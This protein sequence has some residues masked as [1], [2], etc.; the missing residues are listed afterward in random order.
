MN[1]PKETNPWRPSRGKEVWRVRGFWANRSGRGLPFLRPFRGLSR[2]RFCVEVLFLA[3]LIVTLS[4]A[5]G[6]AAGGPLPRELTLT[7]PPPR[8]SFDPRIPVQ[9]PV[10]SGPPSVAGT[11]PEA[12]SGTGPVSVA[13]GISGEFGAS[14][15]GGV[16]SVPSSSSLTETPPLAVSAA[17]TYLAQF[18]LKMQGPADGTIFLVSGSP[19]ALGQAFQT[20]LAPWA[21]GGTR[22]WAYTQPPSVPRGVPIV[23]LSPPEALGTGPIHP[24]GL[25]VSLAHPI[26]SSGCGGALIPSEVQNAYNVTPVLTSGDQGQGETLGIVDTY[27]PTEPP[28]LLL[29][30]LGAFDKCY[31]L[32]NPAVTFAFPVP[33]GNMNSSGSTGWAAEDALDLEWAHAMAPRA[34]IVMVFSPNA[35]YGLYYG[36]DW[37]VANRMA[38]VISLSWGE[39]EI[40]TYNGPCDFQCNAT[41]DGSLALLGPV[42]DRAAAEGISVF[43][44]SGDCGANGGTSLFTPWYPASDPHAIGVGGTVLTLSSTGGYGSETAWS[45]TET[46]CTNSG[47]SGGGFSILGRPPWQSGP[48][49]GRFLQTTRGVP[50]V[51]LTAG[52]PLSLIL[53][54]SAVAVEGTSD[55]APQ[56][57]GLGALLAERQGGGV[58]GFLAPKLY[59]ILNS[60]NYTRDFHPILTGNN[61][62]S[63]GYG[64]DPLTGIGTPDFANLLS[65]L[66]ALP[67]SPG[68]ATGAIL[69]SADPL[70]GAV[71]LPVSFAVRPEGGSLAPSETQYYFGDVGLPFEEA[72]ASTEAGPTTFVYENP[73]A[74][75]AWAAGYGS[76][77]TLSETTPV[78]INV[79]NGGPLQ[80]SLSPTLIQTQVGQSVSFNATASRGEPPYHYQYFF[81]DG[82][83]DVGWASSGADMTHVF[84]TNGT[85]LVTVVANDSSGP[86][87]G[88]WAEVCVQ[89]GT[90]APPCPSTVPPLV[91]DVVTGATTL[92]SGMATPLSIWVTQNGVPVG[93]ASVTLVTGLGTLRQTSGSTDP[94]GYFNTTYQ[95]PSVNQTTPVFLNVS[96]VGPG[97]EP[98]EGLRLIHVNPPSGPSL[99]P[100]VR[101]LQTSVISGSTDGIIF[102]ATN[103]VNGSP[104]S[105]VG[106]DLTTS[107]GILARETGTLG[108]G[109]IAAT[110]LL[111]PSNSTYDQGILTLR[112]KGPGYTPG[113]V[114]ANWTLLSVNASGGANL[115]LAPSVPSTVSLGTLTVRAGATPVP[116]GMASWGDSGFHFGDTLGAVFSSA[117]GSPESPEVSVIAPPVSSNSTDILF[118]NLT[119]DTGEILGSAAVP[120]DLV[121]GAGT[122]EV[123]TEPSNITSPPSFTTTIQLVVSGFPAFGNASGP[124]PLG[125]VSLSA[126]VTGGT[127]NGS[128]WLTGFNGTVDV[129]WTA[130]SA[131]G[132]YGLTVRADAPPYLPSLQRF[133]LHVAPE[134]VGLAGAPQGLSGLDIALLVGLVMIAAVAV[135]FLSRRPR[136]PSLPPPVETQ[137]RGRPEWSEDE[138]PDAMTR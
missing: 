93:G 71:P 113:S 135:G 101:L 77:G 72:N 39:P 34:S 7:N 87:R 3:F 58:P 94:E 65:S 42:L 82:T 55:A 49:F 138:G 92:P 106:F 85:Y 74:Y 36:V 53:N 116:G 91:V 107:L 62:Y 117:W 41:T 104:V 73:G 31:G 81:G 61:G 45:G 100:W 19:S 12:A 51:A 59:R 28:S 10:L 114:Q 122:M 108:A 14:V 21:Q 24:A 105:G 127:L 64:W 37:L 4:S 27:D 2:V 5:P 137:G 129:S 95:A 80:V 69:L 50:D 11:R 86:T 44:A 75:V 17:R 52:T 47:G 57:A 30:D 67:P 13:I 121:P 128:Q 26:P 33:G 126:Q 22:G 99:I 15:S 1:T 9:A 124:V 84:H 123:M 38:D 29:S 111:T 46:Y 43:V 89:V 23:A 97:G 79:G 134:S 68:I 102:G 90:G 70:A 32:P 25:V 136:N 83:T 35:G 18:G 88:G 48:G 133:A 112:V 131:Y 103:A 96:V 119:G 120:L 132:A 54:G 125:D 98:G 6:V 40:G 76:N 118:V 60:A 78:V 8:T 63:A 109:G 110:T 16:R 20:G 115:S 56:W 66:L 130:P